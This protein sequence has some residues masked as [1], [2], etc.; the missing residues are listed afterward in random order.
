M[1]VRTRQT[2][3][4]FSVKIEEASE[5]LSPGNGDWTV[6]ESQWVAGKYPHSYVLCVTVASGESSKAAEARVRRQV[7]KA[8]EAKGAA[9][10]EYIGPARHTSGDYLRVV[11]LSFVCWR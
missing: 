4:N 11:E 3:G 9:Y 10:L 6:E 7:E 1:I 8:A 2:Q 5:V